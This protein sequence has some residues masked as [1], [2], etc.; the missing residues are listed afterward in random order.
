MMD[1]CHGA[2]GLSE[3]ACLADVSADSGTKAPW[4]NSFCSDLALEA[5]L[6]ASSRAART[7]VARP[8]RWPAAMQVRVPSSSRRQ[9]VRGWG[10]PSRTATASV[11]L[12]AKSDRRTRRAATEQLEQSLARLQIGMIDLV[13]IHEV[14]RES[15]PKRCLL[16]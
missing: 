5:L 16:S 6:T 7:S 11:Y 1:Y 10:R 8:L 4:V 15:D 9:F 12:M 2:P 14:I 3:E 13:Q